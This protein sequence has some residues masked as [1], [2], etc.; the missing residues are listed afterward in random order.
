MSSL[1]PGDGQTLKTLG[2]I[3][4]ALLLV[5]GLCIGISLAI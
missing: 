3:I 4:G 1:Q 2:M 5:M